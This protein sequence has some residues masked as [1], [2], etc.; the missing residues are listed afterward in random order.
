MYVQFPFS[1]YVTT[2]YTTKYSCTHKTRSSTT[3]LNKLSRGLFD[4]DIIGRAEVAVTFVFGMC[5]VGQSAR[6]PAILTKDLRRFPQPP[7]DKCQ[8][9]ASIKQPLPS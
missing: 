5:P 8:D 3:K 7:G 1:Y 9:S 4:G 6:T 2:D